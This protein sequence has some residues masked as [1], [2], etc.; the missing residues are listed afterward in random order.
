MAASVTPRQGHECVKPIGNLLRCEI[1]RSRMATGAVAWLIP[2]VKNGMS[3]GRRMGLRF[4]RQFQV[5]KQDCSLRCSGGDGRNRIYSQSISSK[6]LLSICKASYVSAA[7]S[8]GSRLLPL[9]R[10]SMP[11]RPRRGLSQAATEEITYHILIGE[12][13]TEHS[14]GQT[15]ARSTSRPRT[16]AG[17][18][19]ARRGPCWAIAAVTRL[20]R[21][22]PPSAGW[23]WRLTARTLRVSWPSST[24]ASAK[25][26]E[27][28]PF[29][30]PREER[31]RSRRRRG[32]R[33][34]GA[35]DR[36]RSRVPV[37]ARSVQDTRITRC[38]L[39]ARPR[40]F[41]YRDFAD[42]KVGARSALKLAPQM[43]DALVLECRA[44]V[45]QGRID[46]AVPSLAALVR[47]APN[48][49]ALHL[50]YAALLAEAGRNAAARSGFLTIWSFHP[51]KHDSLYTLGLLALQDK[52]FSIHAATQQY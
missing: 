40:A 10:Q 39:R 25:P 1:R 48:K 37:L 7:C 15:A 45:A 36:L 35:G 17:P 30:G 16:S 2:R 22:P 20:P 23:T 3:W 6:P 21:S 24:R 50:A 19:L 52:D 32:G 41:H 28:R 9:R 34:V 46:E 49:L 18:A 51:R 29:R 5:Q 12:L 43:D 11:R 47:A 44:L 14:D 26:V 33:T 13:A 42:A 4:F 8:L 31:R 38:P 27:L